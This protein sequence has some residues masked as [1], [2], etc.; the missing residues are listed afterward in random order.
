M[1]PH[2]GLFTTIEIIDNGVVLIS[3][4]AQCN[5]PF[6]LCFYMLYIYN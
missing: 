2:K 4:D 3:N 1:C 5:V 6:S